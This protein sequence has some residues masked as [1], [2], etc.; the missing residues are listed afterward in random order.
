MIPRS[1]MPVY[2]V[3]TELKQ[4]RNNFIIQKRG[5]LVFVYGKKLR[6][7]RLIPV[8][9][10]FHLTVFVISHFLIMKAS[11]SLISFVLTFAS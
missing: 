4:A 10:V 5:P 6:W 1:G 7:T 2:M 3:R 9:G 11:V 8:L